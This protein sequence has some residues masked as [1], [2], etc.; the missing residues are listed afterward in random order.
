MRLLLA[1]AFAL[2]TLLTACG[3][4]S[5]GGSG[6][7]ANEQ[8]PSGSNRVSVQFTEPEAGVVFTTGQP[9]AVAARVTADGANAADGTAVQFSTASVSASGMT[10]AGLAT[11]S[12]SGVPAGRQSLQATAV[13]GGSTASTTRTVYLRPAPSALQVLL[14]A[15][16]YPTGS[17]ATAWAAMIAGAAAYPGA[18]ITAILNPSNGPSSS[19]DSIIASTASS[20]V[21]AG[22]QLVGYVKTG[23]GQRSASTVKNEIDAYFSYYPGLIRGIFLDQMAATSTELAFYEDVYQYIKAKD[24]SLLVIGNPGAIPVADYAQAT[25]VLAT[26]EGKGSTYASYDPRTLATDWV[27]TQSNAKQGA[28]IHNVADCAAMQTALQAAASARNQ[29]GWVYMTDREYEPSTG[30]GNP[31]GGLPTYWTAL[32]DAVQRTNAGQALAPC[33]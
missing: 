13:A 17:G 21:N 5:S 2:S 10:S 31:W 28:L 29:A 25:D 3:G 8:A 22:G 20:F 16:F 14:P 9:L 6:G 32:L 15:Y 24:S 12:L 1:T 26:F 30:V 11:A 23:W 27:Y 19:A 18:R 4:G 33:A 7:D